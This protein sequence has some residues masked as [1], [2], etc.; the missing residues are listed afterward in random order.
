MVYST[1]HLLLI[2]LI[3]IQLPFFVLHFTLG[4]DRHQTYGYEPA[5]ERQATKE[6]IPV[7]KRVKSRKPYIPKYLRREVN[8]VELDGFHKRVK[9][10]PTDMSFE[11]ADHKYRL[12]PT[13]DSNREPAITESASVDIRIAASNDSQSSESIDNKPS[14]SDDSQSSESIDTKPSA[15]VETLQLS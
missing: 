2:T 11:D 10:V 3:V 6:E 9:R 13:A 15:S 4:I 7:E 8:K 5:M 1:R 14:A 12:G